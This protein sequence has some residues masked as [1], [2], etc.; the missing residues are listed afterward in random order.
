V[1]ADLVLGE[2]SYLGLEWRLLR[3]A[4]RFLLDSVLARARATATN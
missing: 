1:L 4:P 3:A 2:Q